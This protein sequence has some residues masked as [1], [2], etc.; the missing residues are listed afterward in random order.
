MQIQDVN[1][2]LDITEYLIDEERGTIPRGTWHDIEIV[3]DDLAYIMI[4]MYVQGF[5]Q[6][7][8]DATV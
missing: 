2:E 5:I 7:R 6:S 3:P 1:A 8:G 4:D